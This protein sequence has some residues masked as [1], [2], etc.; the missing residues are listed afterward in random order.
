MSD[1][2]LMRRRQ[3]LKAGALGAGFAAL[4]GAGLFS[5]GPMAQRLLGAAAAAQTYIE[6][7]PTSPLILNPFTDELPIPQAARPVGSDP[8][9][10]AAYFSQF[11]G[12]SRAQA[13]DP[14]KGGVQDANGAVHQLGPSDVT[15]KGKNLPYPHVY[16]VRLETGTHKFTNSQV[17][18]IKSVGQNVVAPNGKGA[19]DLPASIITGF[20]AGPLGS[21]VG[22]PGPRINAMYGR[23]VI[24]R[25]DNQMAA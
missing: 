17:Q 1:Q 14:R 9:S 11:K 6:V 3:L 10:V 2:F 7:F 13:P 5:A 24:L 21:A 15:Y 20:N 8:N 25:F 12:E 16:H 4:G 18:P 19:Q 22:F 23:P